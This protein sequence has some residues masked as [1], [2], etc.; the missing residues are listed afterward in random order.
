MNQLHSSKHKITSERGQTMVE[1]AF[2]APVLCLL[3]LAIIQFGILYSSY[4]TL[5]DATRAGARKAAVSRLESKP[6]QVAE[7]A[8]RNSAKNLDEPCKADSGLCVSVSTKA[9]AHGE[10]VTVEATYPYEIDLLGFVFKKGRL[11]STT[12]ERVE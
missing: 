1:F 6:A 5:T 10:D 2:V 3:L 4:V 11:K 12:T 8:V 9:W 7:V